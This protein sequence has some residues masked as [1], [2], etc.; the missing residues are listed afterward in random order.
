MKK[1]KRGKDEPPAP[2]P[3]PLAEILKAPGPQVAPLHVGSVN[4]ESLPRESWPNPSPAELATVAAACGW[5]SDQSGPGRAMELLW[6]CAEA[7]HESKASAERFTSECRQKSDFTAE[8]LA[9]A[10]ACGFDCQT[11]PDQIPL[12]G[13]LKPFNLNPLQVKGRPLRG[14]DLFAHWMTLPDGG[15]FTPPAFKKWK[16]EAEA[17]GFDYRNFSFS[18]RWEFLAILAVRFNEWRKA[19]AKRNKGTGKKNLRRGHES[20]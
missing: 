7:I 16:R 18:L 10:C 9:R 12:S 17:K 3:L 4:L 15:G 2:E 13:F 1:A 6:R 20:S 11:L 8:Q 5:A 14:H 19:T